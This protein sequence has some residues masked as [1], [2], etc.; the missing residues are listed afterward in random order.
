MLYRMGAA[1]SSPHVR[2]RG[3]RRS[4][5]AAQSTK[6]S[7]LLSPSRLF[8]YL[9]RVRGSVPL[10]SAC[11]CGLWQQRMPSRMLTR[12]ARVHG[13][14]Q[15]EPRQPDANK[16]KRTKTKA[17]LSAR[18]LP[19]SFL[20]R[21]TPCRAKSTTTR[22]C[23]KVHNRVARRAGAWSQR[24]RKSIDVDPQS[25]PELRTIRG[26]LDDEPE[27]LPGPRPCRTAT[28]SRVRARGFD[29]VTSE[30]PATSSSNPESCPNS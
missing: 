3:M 20:H 4:K 5:R 14:T 11:A 23:S 21:R 25:G 10:T 7:C 12:V 24:T 18:Q 22:R 6:H 17:R 16:H 27:L 15:R 30:S 26:S 28:W 2:Y 13:P 8:A 9:W 1:A 19:P 29:R